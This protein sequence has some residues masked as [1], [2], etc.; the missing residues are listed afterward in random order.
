VKVII[1]YNIHDESLMLQRIN[2]VMAIYNRK[3]GSLIKLS[4]FPNDFILNNTE[5]ITQ[6]ATT[7]TDNTI[8]NTAT[9][10][11]LTNAGKSEKYSNDVRA[12]LNLRTILPNSL[13][14]L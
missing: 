6:L 11:T 3:N 9:I 5:G 8:K 13:P 2:A 10:V 12:E 1:N 4:S 7:S 14:P